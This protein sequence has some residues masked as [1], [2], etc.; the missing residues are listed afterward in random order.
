ME[1]NQGSYKYICSGEKFWCPR[2]FGLDSVWSCF[3]DFPLLEQSHSP[4]FHLNSI[5]RFFFFNYT[6]ILCIQIHYTYFYPYFLLNLIKHCNPILIITL[7]HL[8]TLSKDLSLTIVC[9]SCF[10][11][12]LHFP[13]LYLSL[14]Y[15]KPTFTAFYS[16][17][18]FL[19]F[20][21]CLP[22]CCCASLCL[23]VQFVNHGC[24]FVLWSWWVRCMV[25][26]AAVR[27]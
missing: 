21:L 16:I 1:T 9:I 27:R 15:L 12:P 8:R 18:C 22:F 25:N 11:F 2:V 17:H 14:F 23:S 4:R 20:F 19:T 24:L 13:L 10:Y 3:K 6:S 5:F 26:K 7:K